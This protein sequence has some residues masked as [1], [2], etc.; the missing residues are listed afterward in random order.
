[1]QQADDQIYELPTNTKP[2]V[3]YMPRGKERYGPIFS[4][5]DKEIGLVFFEK[6]FS[7]LRIS[8]SVADLKI[9]DNNLSF[10]FNV[11][12]K[13]DHITSDDLNSKQFADLVNFSLN[14]LFVNIGA[15]EQEKDKQ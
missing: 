10:K 5:G 6:P 9:Q 12:D 15:W 11:E 7:G 14:D 4:E 13:P 8:I 3:V 1:M 2:R